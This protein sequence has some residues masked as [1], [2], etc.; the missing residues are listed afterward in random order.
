MY[1]HVP[2]VMMLA[3]A[4]WPKERIHTGLGLEDNKHIT[5]C[6]S[7]TNLSSTDTIATTMNGSLSL[8][9]FKFLTK[10]SC[11]GRLRTFHHFI[12]AIGTT[13]HFISVIKMTTGATA[14][15]L[16]SHFISGLFW[17]TSVPVRAS[18]E[19]VVVPV[20]Y[21]DWH[22]LPTATQK[23]YWL[24]DGYTA[25]GER[26]MKGYTFIWQYGTL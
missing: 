22:S 16:R 11:Q 17:L 26:N 15:T 4:R 21:F 3:L 9:T 5:W 25:G 8:T 14:N 7:Q 6:Q 12:S 18:S 23:R 13:V 2:G 19:K 1:I 10:C 24:L 20:S